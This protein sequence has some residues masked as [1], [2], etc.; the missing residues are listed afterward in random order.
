[1]L[2]Y[3]FCADVVY[4]VFL[5]LFLVCFIIFSVSLGIKVYR[6]R[7]IVVIVIVFILPQRWR[8]LK[9]EKHVEW[10]TA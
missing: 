8:N 1:V 9:N 7:V 10:R 2:V 4:F 3:E 6:E 5:G